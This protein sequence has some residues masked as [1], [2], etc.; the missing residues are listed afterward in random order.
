[1]EFLEREICIWG[2][3]L[4]GYS[5]AT[6]L[7][8]GG[9]KCLLIDIDVERVARINAHRVPFDHGTDSFV[10]LS[11]ESLGNLRACCTTQ[12]RPVNRSSIHF[13]CIPTEVSGRICHSALK[14]VI[15]TLVSFPLQQRPTYILIESTISPGW[16][17]TVVHEIFRNAGWIH[18]KHYHVGCSPRRDV[19]G[20][21]RTIANVAKIY[22]ADSSECSD[23][24]REIYSPFCGRL[25]QASDAKHAVL[26]KIVENLFRY[27]AIMLANQLTYLMPTF[28]MAEV[29][30]LAGT[31]WNMDQYH[32][33][34]G[35]GG[36]CVPLA[37]DY[38]AASLGEEGRTSLTATSDIEPILANCFLRRILE[39]S[40][41]RKI[42][43]LGLSYAPDLRV[44]TLSPSLRAI[45]FFS[46]NNCEVSVHDPYYSRDEI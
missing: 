7:A 38:L 10:S 30:S 37:K 21:D 8:R 42:S 39:I 11:P 17:D 26:T 22:G 15:N 27:Q 40:V 24:M 33:S 44:H 14:E 32:P 35:I 23:L 3:G 16:I 12:W 45:R 29:L 46:A 25:Y 9:A 18:K 13:L 36:Y 43:I 6:Y 31:K 4:V 41:A 2:A 20:Q 34:L 5:L 19:F 28:N 1:M